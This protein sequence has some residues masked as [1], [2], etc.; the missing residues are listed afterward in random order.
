MNNFKYLYMFVLLGF[1][2]LH[3]FIEAMKNS[4]I[5]FTY[6]WKIAASCDKF[7]ARLKK[8]NYS[9]IHH[10]SRSKNY[11]CDIQYILN[12]GWM[13]CCFCL[14]FWNVLNFTMQEELGSHTGKNGKLGK[15]QYSRALKFV[16]PVSQE[17]WPPRAIFPR[18]YGP[19]FGNLAPSKKL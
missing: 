10:V 19:L 14:V 12:E 2:C 11:K 8:L 4:L 7:R 17:I 6:F 15:S 18:K 3:G 16:S 5:L 13:W 9:W 1:D